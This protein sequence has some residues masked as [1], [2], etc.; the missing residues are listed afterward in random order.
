MQLKR[1]TSQA[2]SRVGNLPG[3]TDELMGSAPMNR[4]HA[5][6]VLDALVSRGWLM[7]SKFVELVTISELMVRRARYSLGTRALAELEPWFKAEYEDIVFQ[8]ASCMKI[9]TKVRQR[10]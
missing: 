4:A 5:D 9:V 2:S 8:C 6:D 7:K 10:S 3:G 1:A